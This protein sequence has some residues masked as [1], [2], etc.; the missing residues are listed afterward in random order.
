MPHFRHSSGQLKAPPNRDALLPPS[1]RSTA[2]CKNVRCGIGAG[3]P[4]PPLPRPEN[5]GS[6]PRLPA[7][8]TE[9]NGG[10]ERPTADAPHKGERS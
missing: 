6:G 7:Q 4:Y 1:Q 3:L 5:K 8:R 10:A 9:S 2:A